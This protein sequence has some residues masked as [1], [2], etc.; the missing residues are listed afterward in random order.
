[1][2]I[3]S[4]FI[5]ALACVNINAAA[6]SAVLGD[7]NGDSVV[8][9]TDVSLAAAQVKSIKPLNDD[10]LPAADVNGD[11]IVN[12]TDISMIAAHVKSVKLLGD[13]GS[14][15]TSDNNGGG[16]NGGGDPRDQGTDDFWDIAPDEDPTVWDSDDSD[17]GGGGNDQVDPAGV[18]DPSADGWD[19]L[20]DPGNDVL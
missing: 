4:V 19:D 10:V 6:D 13:D 8:N 11:D 12:V 1:M 2:K 9:V 5:A 3:K 15:A 14:D 20:P 7:I 17:N 18:P 16:N